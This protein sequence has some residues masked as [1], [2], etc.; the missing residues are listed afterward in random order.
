MSQRFV[1]FGELLLRLSAPSRQLLLQ[2]PALEVHIGGAEANVAVALSRLGHPVRMV[3]R[4]PDNALGAAAVGELR[5]HG[6]D[7][8]R[9]GHGAGRMG[10]YFLTP[11]AMQRPSEV[12]YDRAHS[13]FAIADGRD[14]DWSACLAGSDWFHLSGITPA[15]GANTAAMA[16]DAAK[17]ARAAGLRVSFDCNYRSQLWQAWRGDAKALLTRCFE[18]ADIV[19][20]DP[21]DVAIVLGR[22]SVG[23]TPQARFAD[24]ANACFAHFPQLRWFAATIRVAHSV[25]QQLLGAVLAERGAELAEVAPTLLNDIVDRIGAGDAFAAGLLHGLANGEPAARAL[26]LGHAAA[27]LKHGI[28]GDFPLLRRADLDAFL[29]DVPADVKR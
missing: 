9:V 24:A 27:C 21:R 28:P 4:V 17:A 20:G 2:S 19:F 13:A 18:Q 10:L 16:I 15:L 5:R 25:D 23:D 26:R 22:H 3:S 11:G 29:A 12:L 8:A 6:V 14:H 7:T 1:C